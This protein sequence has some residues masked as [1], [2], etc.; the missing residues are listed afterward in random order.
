MHNIPDISDLLV[1]LD[2]AINTHFIPAL[3]GHG[4]ISDLEWQLLALPTWLGGLGIA[5]PSKIAPFKHS[6]STK[7]TAP[8]VALIVKQNPIYTA[9]NATEQQHAKQ[10]IRMLR[11]SAADQLQ[12]VLPRHLKR[13]IRAL[14]RGYLPFQ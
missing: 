3:S 10:E 14:P 9:T 2:E 8:L 12:Q 5:I 6:S 7:V 1:P 13:A 11:R 4:S